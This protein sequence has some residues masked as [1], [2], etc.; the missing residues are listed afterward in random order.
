[1]RME[2]TKI[3]TTKA[4]RSHKGHKEN[5]RTNLENRKGTKEEE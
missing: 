2:I 3:F 1:M 5:R 4:Q